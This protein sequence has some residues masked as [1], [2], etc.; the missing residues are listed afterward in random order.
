[1]H[2]ITLCYVVLFNVEEKDHVID[3]LKDDLKHTCTSDTSW[4]QTSE[5][6]VQAM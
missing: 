1:M 5:S 2:S 6:I 4:S 3:E